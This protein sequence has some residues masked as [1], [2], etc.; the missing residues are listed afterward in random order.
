MIRKPTRRLTTASAPSPAFGDSY[1]NDILLA[2]YRRDFKTA[3]PLLWK[4]WWNHPTDW[5]ILKCAV[6]SL[7]PTRLARRFPGAV[8]VLIAKEAAPPKTPK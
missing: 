1:R 4:W 2:Y 6:I 7:F 5:Y 3:R 8:P